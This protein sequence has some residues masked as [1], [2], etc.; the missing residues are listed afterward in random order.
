MI[1]SELTSKVIQCA[2]VMY[3]YLE[4]PKEAHQP[5]LR[6]TPWTSV[7]LREIASTSYHDK[8]EWPMI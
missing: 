7:K 8:I 6:V 2:T 3:Q 5:G 4:W 1:E